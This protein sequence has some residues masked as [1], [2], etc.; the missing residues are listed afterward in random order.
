MLAFTR[1]WG[2]EIHIGN[3]IVVKIIN[4][5]GKQVRVSVEAPKDVK[6]FRGEVIKR[7]EKEITND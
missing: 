7:Q 6:V 4:S 1:R 5:Y 2:E 3:D